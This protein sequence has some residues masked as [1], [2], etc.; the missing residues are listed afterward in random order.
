MWIFLSLI[1]ALAQAISAALKKKMLQTK[2]MNNVIGFI[3]FGVAAILFWGLF[4]INNSG[5]LWMQ[6]LSWK[7]WLAI[8]IFAGLNIIAVWFLYKALDIAEFNHLMPFLTFSP[9]S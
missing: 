5:D 4:A 6:N 1:G 9:Q 7:F 2:R 3:T 8:I